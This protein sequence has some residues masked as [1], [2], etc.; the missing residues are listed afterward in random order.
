MVGRSRVYGR[1]GPEVADRGWVHRDGDRTQRPRDAVSELPD[2][3][4]S[5]LFSDIEGST[6]LLKRLGPAYAEALDGHREVLRSAWAAHDG[7]ELGTE[8]DS[9]FVA[10]RNPLDA[11][12]AATQGQRDL[13]ARAWP[14]GEQVRVRIGIH[15][16][17]PAVHAGGYVGMDVHRAARIAAAAHGGQIV[18]SSPTAELVRAALGDG[19]SLRDLGGH[20]LKDLPAPEHLYQVSVEGLPTTFPPLKSLGTASNLPRPATPL[21][22]R[23]AELTAL[24]ELL[25][26]EDV[27]LVTLTG[28]GG[29][30]KTRVGIALAQQLVDRFPDGVYF[31]P[32]AAV[33]GADRM[34]VTVAEVLGLPPEQRSTTGLLD[35]L[36]HRRALLVLDN[37]EQLDGAGGVVTRIIDAAPNV[38]VVAASRRPLFVP[39]EHVHAVPPLTLPDHATAASMAGS[40]AVELFVQ[41]ARMVRPGFTLTPDSA[42]DV[43]QLCRRLDGLPL[44]IELAAARTRLLG[45]KALLARLDDA[46]DLATGS[47]Q[48]PSRQRT[49]RETIAW[50]YELLEADLQ[51]FFRRLSVLS[52]GDLEA[53]AAV[54]GAGLA[55]AVDPFDSVVELVDASLLTMTE[56]VDDEPRV[57]MLQ[58]IRAYAQDK[59]TDAGEAHDVRA[60][61]ARHFVAMTEK[62]QDLRESQHLRA[63]N[64]AE[65]ELDNFREALGWTLEA[66]PDGSGGNP[67]LLLGLKLGSNLGWY[68][69]MSGHMNE[70]RDWLERLVERAPAP[71]PEL[72]ACLGDLANLLLGLGDPARA[73]DV[74]G[75]SLRMARTLGERAREAFAYGVLGTAQVQ[76][77]DVSSAAVTLE[78]SLQLHRD[79]GNPGRLARA[80]G[81][82]AGI[83]ELL[84]NYGRAEALT[85]EAINIVEGLGDLHEGAVQ[86]QNLAN[87]LAITD[88]VDEAYQ[89][90]LELVGVVLQLQ[91][92]N[93][94]LAF[95]NTCMNIKLRRHEPRDAARLF[96]A[97][98][99]MRERLRMPN[100]YREE[101]LEE[102]LQ[103]AEADISRDDWDSACDRGRT[104]DLEGLLTAL[105]EPVTS[106]QSS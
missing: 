95:A 76:T 73:R 14:A 102:A 51:R 20:Q 7:T 23:D 97:E 4:V 68:W 93:L 57:A 38:V 103:L 25:R 70:G 99:A 16:G 64:Q 56:G 105:S 39:G 104:E 5:L 87:L 41:Q 94:T 22:G 50:S 61:H 77:G 19:V 37:L 6:A 59:L 100:P 15:T 29:V 80:L 83:Q 65:A 54:T 44:A 75:E 53:V 48:Q 11:V 49:L 42:A 52:G 43:A 12:A 71:S 17:T 32:L 85:R 90:A 101:E 1:R 81:N 46:L 74:A 31:V 92:P 13:A 69:Y 58:T 62:L 9:F 47:R 10:F 55:Q 40:S 82:L 30:G 84:G 28:P 27:R 78:D 36:A 35:L 91:S 18:I 72:C 63:L 26:S 21:L 98:E 45:P 96:G 34:W 33:A 3:T 24:R 60:A 2:G 106:G 67:D 88:R 8:G 66:D 86:R 89:L 79:L